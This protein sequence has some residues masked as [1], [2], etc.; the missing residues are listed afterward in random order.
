M[1]PADLAGAYI[2]L[3]GQDAACMLGLVA[4]ERDAQTLADQFLGIDGTEKELAPEIVRDVICE[5]ANIVV[6]R[7][8]TGLPSFST[9]ISLET[10]LPTYIC[11]Q[12]GGPAILGA[13]AL[14]LQLEKTS[15][16]LV[17]L[18]VQQSPEAR[19]RRRLQGI[20]A[21]RERQLRAILDSVAD[22]VII[23]NTD[24]VVDLV[25]PAAKAMFG[26]GDGEMQGRDVVELLPH[27]DSV[28]SGEET[29]ARRKHGDVF[30]A[31]VSKGSF[32]VNRRRFFA[33]VA[34]DVTARKQAESSLQRT[35]TKLGD[36]YAALQLEAAEL[37]RAKEQITHLANF[38]PLTQLANRRF[39]ESHAQRALQHAADSGTSV[40]LL[41][42]DLD[43]F[44]QINDTLG[45]RAGDEVLKIVASRL[46]ESLR[47]TDCVVRDRLE[48]AR[49]Q[50]RKGSTV[51]RLGGDEFIVVLPDLRRPEDAA[52]VAERIVDQ[53]AVPFT[54][55][56][57]EMHITTS[58]G[59]AI[60][61]ENGGDMESLVS[62]ADC[63][64]YNAKQSGRNR[65]RFFTQELTE[66]ARKRMWLEA[67]LHKAL[68]QGDIINHYQPRIDARTGR[69]VAAEAL[70]RWTHAEAGPIPPDEFVPVAEEIGII[71]PLGAELLRQA[72]RDA[73]QWQSQEMDLSVSVNVAST[74]LTPSFVQ[75][76]LEALHDAEL[77]PQ[78]LEL[79]I[80]ERTILDPSH[81]TRDIL[82]ALR[83]QGIRIHLDDF[84]TGYSSLGY[85]AAFPIDAIKVDRS[86]VSQMVENPTS[87]TVTEA[88]IALARS[89]GLRVVAEGVETQQQSALLKDHGCD[90]CQG[91]YYSKPIP[92]KTLVAWYRR[93][94]EGP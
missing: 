6:S 5:L 79:E 69:V 78:R 16:W 33:T 34:R 15:A 86:F 93:F 12:L 63:A 22:A 3:S 67:E 49:R 9:D 88:I 73:K 89:L 45:H 46:A 35:N 62:N 75:T 25:N 87:A 28:A 27:L 10:G 18:D 55:A 53:L 37:A 39:F 61:P 51:A 57:H 36:A 74:Q 72:C 68:Y 42:L 90:E 83:S 30:P 71:L 44:K 94:H 54:V 11:G 76:V 47:S 13:G 40:A 92:A 48:A 64:M 60:Y 8:K 50:P 41:L 7:I 24:G 52:I 1:P 38:D 43:R 65:Y 84:G 2:T 80:T 32:E 85:L 4:V 91:Y 58:V 59:I 20:L 26:Y 77:S 81:V 70:A 19:E 17:V 23:C 31:E 14:E 56:G 29:T 66:R 21:D 82:Q